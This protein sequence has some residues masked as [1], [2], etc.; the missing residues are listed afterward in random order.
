MNPIT[1]L[2][3]VEQVAE[4]LRAEV[5]RGEL[6]GKMPGVNPLVA[7]LGVGH[8]TVNAALTQLEQEGLLVGQGVGRRRK[9]GTSYSTQLLSFLI[10]S[11]ISLHIYLNNL[12]Y[13]ADGNQG[14]TR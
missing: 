10:R 2:S 14:Q 8:K 4:H 6:S 13:C 7:E 9:I 1:V 3:A 12:S 11:K 5:L